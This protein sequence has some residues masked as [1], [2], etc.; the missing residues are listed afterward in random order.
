MISGRHAN[1]TKTNYIHQCAR[2]SYRHSDRPKI[3]EIVRNKLSLKV[4]AYLRA[5]RFERKKKERSKRYI[6]V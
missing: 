6:R 3:A 4:N 5:E 2:P 1:Y